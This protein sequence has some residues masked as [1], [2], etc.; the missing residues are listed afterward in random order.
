MFS[1][2]KIIFIEEKVNSKKELFEIVSRKAV[3]LGVS[4]SVE[5][6]VKGFEEREALGSTGFQEGLGIPHC[7]SEAVKQPAAFFVRAVVPIEWDTFDGQ[8]LT[9]MFA[10]LIPV[11]GEA[12]HLQVLTKISRKMMNKEFR[13]NIKSTNNPDEI[14]E[15][16]KEIN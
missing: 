10:L 9:N 2:D 12:E 6:L 11:E 7:K 5:A 8:P 14:L 3:E 1:K 4:D 15:L 16:L 13:A